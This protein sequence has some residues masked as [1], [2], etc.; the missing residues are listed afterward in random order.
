MLS[1]DKQALRQRMLD[2]RAELQATLEGADQA[3]ETVELDQT[4]QGRLSR[5]DAMQGQAMAQ[6]AHARASARLIAIERSLAE[7]E[8]D[9]YGECR[10]CGTPIP[11]GRLMIDPTVRY[12][13]ACAEG[14]ENEGF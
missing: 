11:L 8:A 3:G 13:V 12:C 5:M 14:F 9:D 4:R 6:A 10:E 1:D 7:L 2:L